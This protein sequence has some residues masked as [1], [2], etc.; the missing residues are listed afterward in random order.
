MPQLESH[1]FHDSVLLLI[2]HP[3][4][5]SYR[6]ATSTVSVSGTQE[7]V[8]IKRSYIVAENCI[9]IPQIFCG[10]KGN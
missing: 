3:P 5:E 4:P 6:M 10:G 9:M 8:D 1:Q 2:Y 7:R